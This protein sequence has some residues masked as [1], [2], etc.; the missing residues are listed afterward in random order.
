VVSPRSSGSRA[1]RRLAALSMIIVIMLISITGAE[2]L[3]PGQWHEQ[4]KVRLGLDLS[5]GTEV[6]L[7]AQTPR[8]HPPSSAE[9]NQAWSVLESRV[10]GSGNGAQVQRQGGDLLDVS[11]PGAGTQQVINLVS[12]TAQ[13]RFR[14]VLLLQPYGSRATASG[15]YGNASL[16]NAA[17]MKLFGK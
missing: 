14:Q 4:F 1:W 11:V 3:H 15:Y 5:S 13:M 8:G 10:N 16:V 12:T 2:T 6:V 9:M 17:T 7:Q